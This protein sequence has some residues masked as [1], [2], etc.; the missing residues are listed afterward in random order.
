MR[1]SSVPTNSVR[2]E[3]GPLRST[4]TFQEDDISA[5]VYHAANSGTLKDQQVHKQARKEK[6]IVNAPSRK[7]KALVTIIGDAPYNKT[8]SI[9][10]TGYNK[11]LDGKVKD[12]AQTLSADVH[13]S[14]YIGSFKTQGNSKTKYF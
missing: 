10:V 9:K 11:G 8:L 2:P 13:D 6:L 4:E 14:T 3:P 5:K 12:K 1:Q 7:E